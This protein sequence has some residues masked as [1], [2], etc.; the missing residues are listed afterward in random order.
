MTK[1]I[2]SILVFLTSFSAQADMSEIDL[3]TR[4]E[5][6]KFF[7][8]EDITVDPDKDISINGFVTPHNE[9]ICDFEVG[10]IVSYIDKKKKTQVEAC[11]VCFS[12]YKKD[13]KLIS[14]DPEITYCVE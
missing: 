6:V 11:Y 13:G 14:M 4:E 3:M 9:A 5:L 10:A 12:T 1:S 2:L 8:D 7:A